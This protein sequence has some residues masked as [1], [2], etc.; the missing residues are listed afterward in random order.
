MTPE[1]SM[2]YRW[3]QHDDG[4][5]TLTR[6]FWE[7]EQITSIQP[8]TAL[9]TF[10]A[11]A[12]ADLVEHLCRFPLPA[13]AFAPVVASTTVTVIEGHSTRSLKDVLRPGTLAVQ[14]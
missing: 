4:T 3:L 7:G 14:P 8:L 11:Q 5:C 9:G 6:V 1:R 2:T 13:S 12:R 10:D